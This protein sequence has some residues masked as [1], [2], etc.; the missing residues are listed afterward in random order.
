MTNINTTTMIN[1][2]TEQR[3][4][5]IYDILENFILKNNLIEN[6][7]IKNN[8][9][10]NKVAVIIEPRKHKFLEYIIRNV[11]YFCANKNN[12]WNLHVVTCQE[13]SDWLKT[14]LPNW[15]YKISLLP[16]YNLTQQQYNDLLLS[17]DFWNSI[18]EENVLIF[19]T[20]SMMFRDNIDDYLHYDFIGANFF[21]SNDISLTHGGNNGGFSFRHKSAMLD[22]LDK[23]SPTYVE[24]YLK[25]HGKD[26]K[27]N[28]M[29]D[30][31]FSSACEM[32][33]KKLSTIE[34]RKY[35]SIED[36][37]KETC[38][39]PVG[40]HRFASPELAHV[41]LDILKTNNII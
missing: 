30:V 2:T 7:S 41:I 39:T 26:I 27:R 25:S 9:K 5:I 40:C 11:M 20:D 35:F 21:D 23:I 4:D 10:N 6:Q 31:Y 38:M 1:L 36:A 19:Q 22:C 17:K 13:T 28:L 32:I 37:R 29:E 14:K 18:D 15:D 34:D 3:S 33:N 8:I 24:I 16:T 12:D